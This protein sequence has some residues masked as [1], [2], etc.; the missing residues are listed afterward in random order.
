[1]CIPQEGLVCHIVASIDNPLRFGLPIKELVIHNRVL[2][3]EEIT[4][5]RRRLAEKW[6]NCEAP[7]SPIVTTVYHDELSDGDRKL[8]EQHLHLTVTPP[9]G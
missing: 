9:A 2:S 7:S 4:V 6:H 3:P 5:E 1:M 8:V